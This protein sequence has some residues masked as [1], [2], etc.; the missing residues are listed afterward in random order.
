MYLINDETD[1]MP[2]RGCFSRLIWELFTPDFRTVW[3]SKA[4]EYELLVLLIT[5]TLSSIRPRAT[6]IDRRALLFFTRWSST[7]IIRYHLIMR[8][9]GLRSCALLLAPEF[10]SSGAYVNGAAVAICGALGALAEICF[11]IDYTNMYIS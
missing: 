2:N 6:E 7:W 8:M 10:R 3:S 5:G 11:T 4:R 1:T 9:T